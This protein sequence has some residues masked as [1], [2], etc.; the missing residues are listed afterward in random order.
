MQSSNSNLKALHKQQK[1]V[2]A[3]LP[4]N[5]IANL[6]DA[7]IWLAFKHG[8]ETAFIYIYQSYF[9]SLLNYGVNFIDDREVVKDCIQDLF[10]EIREKRSTILVTDSIKPFL[11][12]I[13]RRKLGHFLRK[14][15]DNTELTPAHDKF[16][17]E[18]SHEQHLIERNFSE[19]QIKK[20][21]EA[22]L[23]LSVKER[24]IIFLFYFE[25]HSYQHIAEIMGYREVKTARTLLY[26]AIASLKSKLG[27]GFYSFILAL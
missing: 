26:R 24:E 21:K 1:R 8:N 23:Q 18:L 15:L 7:E 9:H 14:H 4:K 6:S 10:I 17:F 19:W 27:P 20:L 5:E 13:L 22:I 11:Y 16:R 25:D 3:I 2:A 12:K